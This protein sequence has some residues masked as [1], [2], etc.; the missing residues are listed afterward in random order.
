MHRDFSENKVAARKGGRIA[1][2][3]REKLEVETGERV[4]TPENF[5]T[6]P[7]NRKRLK[8]KKRGED[9]P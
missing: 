9:K 6:E 8:A 3:A 5:L 4:V 2:E 1:G 7:E